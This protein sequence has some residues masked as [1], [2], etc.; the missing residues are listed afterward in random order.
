MYLLRTT[1]LLRTTWLLKIISCQQISLE[2]FFFFC[3]VAMD[4]TF[5]LSLRLP[6]LVKPFALDSIRC[7]VMYDFLILGLSG[8]YR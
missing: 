6:H 4:L 8:G 5:R 1:P 3:R 2:A 7:Q